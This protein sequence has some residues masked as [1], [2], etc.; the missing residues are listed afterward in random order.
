M[1]R[2][3]TNC[4]CCSIL[5]IAAT[6][7]AE[8]QFIPRYA[9]GINAGSFIYNG[10]LSP[11]KTG[12]WKTPGFAWGLNGLKYFT[13]T[14]SARLDISFGK[15]RGDEAEYGSPE[16]RRYRAFAFNSSVTEI[17]LGAEWSPA[18]RD[19]KLSPYLFG[20][21]G[22]SGMK[23]TRDY[24]RFNESYFVGEPS[25]KETLAQDAA[26]SLPRGVAIFPVGLGLNY[27]LNR[28]LSL[29]GEAAHR[30][31]RSDYVDGFSYAG[32]PDQKDSYTKYSVGIRY[33][34]GNKDP[35]ACPP[36]RY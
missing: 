29:T 24:S 33:S 2:S 15:L 30:F 7:T 27:V 31:T 1:K 8:A 9:V 10:D 21:I 12:S 28:K 32:N 5:S 11:W 22:Y 35:Y 25:L 16:F 14:L 36:M 6:I 34:I 17:V 23:I 26:S 4:L 19:R 3:L 18:G 20:G 13:S